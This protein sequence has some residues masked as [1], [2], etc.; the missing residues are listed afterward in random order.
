MSPGTA[1]AAGGP[2][3]GRRYGE[4]QVR[5]LEAMG[6]TAWVA[7]PDRARAS[8]QGG[9]VPPTP[10]VVPSPATVEGAAGATAAAAESPA[11]ETPATTAPVTT[12]PAVGAPA[13]EAAPVGST[14]T[15]AV[16]PVPSPTPAGDAGP[17]SARRVRRFERRG[18][19]TAE[20]RP[21][22]GRVLVL[23]EP[24]PGEA[25]PSGAPLGGEPASLFLLMLRSIGLGVEDVSLC[26]LEPAGTESGP[27]PVPVADGEGAEVP[28]P[29]VRELLGGARRTALWLV[30]DAGG[31]GPVDPAGDAPLR[32]L[33]AGVFRVPHPALLLERPLV[34]REA[35]AALKAARRR[36]AGEAPAAGPVAPGRPG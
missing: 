36:L 33:G 31:A 25:D 17:L 32:A 5:C 10:T 23:V 20:T 7:R 6:L 29:A 9:S 12:A 16:A 27:D 13:V 2:R 19:H 35:W 4:R 21:G 24:A 8:A 11:V 15:G 34:K 28:A 22:E 3:V 30:H 18:R 26:A 14:A 1:R